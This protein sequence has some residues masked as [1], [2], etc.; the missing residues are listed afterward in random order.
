MT[1]RIGA[2]SGALLARD[3]L[4]LEVLFMLQSCKVPMKR[5]TRRCV[6]FDELD[7]LFMFLRQSC[8]DLSFS[9]MSYRS[10]SEFVVFRS[11]SDSWES[12]K[13]PW[14]DACLSFLDWFNLSL[15]DAPALPF[16]SLL[17]SLLDS[18]LI[19]SSSSIS[20]IAY[21]WSLYLLFGSSSAF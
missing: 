9:F 20:M 8:F 2:K 18:L 3:I 21:Y 4:D 16:L 19:L 10:A 15:L 11:C 5:L 1:L 6:S 7:R 17:P 14:E 13:Q 12:Y